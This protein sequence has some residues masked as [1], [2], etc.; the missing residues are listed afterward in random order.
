MSGSGII[1]IGP[2]DEDD[3]NHHQVFPPRQVNA[4]IGFGRLQWMQLVAA[5]DLHPAGASER[6]GEAILSLIFERRMKG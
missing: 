2:T 1:I 3:H 5:L 4:I 6:R